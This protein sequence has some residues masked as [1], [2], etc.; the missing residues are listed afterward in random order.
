MSVK[1]RLGAMMFLEYAIWGSW[2]PVL[3]AYLQNNLGFTGAQ[4][5]IIFS[6]LPLAT[7][8]SPFLGGQL[9]DRWFPTQKVIGVL[10]LLGGVILILIASITSFGAMVWLMLLYCLV[11]APTLALTNSIAM[12]NLRSSEKEFGS[13]RV[14]GTIGWI[15]AGWALTGW[16]FAA[17]S[18]EGIA[19]KGDVLI[20]AGIFSL[21]MGV[22]SFFLP[23]TPPQKGGS[24][25]WAFLEA[26]KMLKD[27]NFLIFAVISFVVATELQ[28]YYVLTSPFLTSA[29]IGVSQKSIGAVMTIAQ[30]AEI[31]VMA[32]M[33]SWALKKFGMRRT[34]TL[35]ILAWPI[36]YII[37]VIG[38]PSWLVIGSLALHGFCYVFFF[39][40]AYIYVD[41]IA[42]KDIR[43]SAQSLIATIILG[44]GNFVGSL[45]CGWIQ[46]VFTTT[47]ATAG[48]E[49]VKAINW[50]GAF[51]V[52]TALTL[53]CLIV[54][55]AFF[56]E[57]KNAG[58]QAT[59]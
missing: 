39:T 19:L 29:A 30:F 35:G 1:F 4:L 11:Y 43:N 18:P 47:A 50:R 48:G 52:P 9:A 21:V 33:L 7:I 57:K 15:A 49:A 37:F 54:F 5:G 13:I 45:F 2:A 16:R 17:K 59:V 6:L 27:R 56:R 25:P 8:V 53:L 40:A 34:L 22:I 42:P 55:L 23:H 10:S 46:D 14:W 24:N 26:L 38:Q 20:L 58:A 3:S 28:F 32:F 51:L 44:F 36:R 41:S 12:V 31:F